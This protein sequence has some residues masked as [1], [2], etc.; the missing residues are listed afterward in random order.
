[1]ESTHY[2]Y[3]YYYYYYRNRDSAVGITTGYW[4]DDQGV[5][6]RVPNRL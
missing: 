6:F 2:Y 3:Y 1:M 5:G 4:L